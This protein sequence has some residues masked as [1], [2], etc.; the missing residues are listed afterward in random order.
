MRRR[1][2]APLLNWRGCAG[3]QRPC[4]A[5]AGDS[6]AFGTVGCAPAASQAARAHAAK[7]TEKTRDKR[8]TPERKPARKAHTEGSHRRL[9]RKARAK[10]S[11]GRPAQKNREQSAE[12]V[13]QGRVRRASFARPVSQG[14]IRRAG[15]T[16]PDSM[17]RPRPNT[18]CQAHAGQACAGTLMRAGVANPIWAGAAA[19]RGHTKALRAALKRDEL[20]LLPGPQ[21]KM[22][23][24]EGA[25]GMKPRSWASRSKGSRAM[26]SISRFTGSERS[27][28]LSVVP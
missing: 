13:S 22:F 1:G 11:H 19:S 17:R 23:Q 24:G 6:C 10:G 25:S 18:P 12:P 2:D 14:Q 26:H 21:L 4:P 8:P 7:R 28:M 15:F 27:T 9:A 16:R 3:R 20:P 5:G